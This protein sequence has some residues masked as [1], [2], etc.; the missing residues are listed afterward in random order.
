MLADKKPTKVKRLKSTNMVG[1]TTTKKTKLNN[2]NKSYMSTISRSPL[3]P[4]FKTPN[5]NSSSFLNRSQTSKFGAGKSGLYGQKSF[6][7][8]SQYGG[9]GLKNN[10]RG[11]NGQS[12]SSF[13][14][15]SDTRFG[16]SRLGLGSSTIGFKNNYLDNK[17][18]DG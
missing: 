11:P 9:I 17:R 16:G 18:K 15:H 1:A 3:R 2:W 7:F 13:G 8:R 10:L 12:V 5:K 14:R 4:R 6:G